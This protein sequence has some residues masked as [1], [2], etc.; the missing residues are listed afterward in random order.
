MIKI[1][2]P[3]THTTQEQENINVGKLQLKS[4]IQ[5][6][7]RSLRWLDMGTLHGESDV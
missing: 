3:T 7:N 1:H 4:R 2:T 5:R 6:E